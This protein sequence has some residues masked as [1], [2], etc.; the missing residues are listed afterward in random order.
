MSA[1]I[2]T[3]TNPSFQPQSASSFVS[4]RQLWTGR[5]LSGLAAALLIL[6]GGAKVFKAPPVVES[7]TRLGYPESTIV[8]IGALL[9]VCTMLYLFP[10]TAIP[11]AV[12]LTGYLGGAVTT[13]LRVQGPV[14]PI[15]F[16]V[17]FGIVLWIGIVL[18]DARVRSI[19]FQR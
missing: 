18:R 6:D 2:P 19:L 17:L 15:V 9:L 5:L 4:K 11:G 16:P 8:G 12:L 10:R 1:F 7:M 13:N 3:A 14:F